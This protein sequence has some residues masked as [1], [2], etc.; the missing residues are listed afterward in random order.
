MSGL[1]FVIRRVSR[2]C[3]LVAVGVWNVTRISSDSEFLARMFN[4][5]WNA[6]RDMQHLQ[7]LNQTRLPQVWIWN[8]LRASRLESYVW[9]YFISI[10]SR[11]FFWC[12]VSF[13]YQPRLEFMC[14]SRAVLI[15]NGL[16]LGI[17]WRMSGICYFRG[18]ESCMSRLVFY[19]RSCLSSL[20]AWRLNCSKACWFTKQTWQSNLTLNLNPKP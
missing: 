6:R 7:N 10:A 11:L 16:R 3:I 13:S 2:L 14:Q 15:L 5:Q 18:V 8:E 9:N 19:R 4:M 17:C 20:D 1:V 12:R